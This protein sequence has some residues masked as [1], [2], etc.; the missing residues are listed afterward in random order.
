M[1]G[2]TIVTCYLSGSSLLPNG[3]RLAPRLPEIAGFSV[4]VLRSPSQPN[5]LRRAAFRSPS[6]E[7]QPVE[8]GGIEPPSAVA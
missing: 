4:A 5:F 1:Q 8:T 2:P 3:Y 6:Q 7:V